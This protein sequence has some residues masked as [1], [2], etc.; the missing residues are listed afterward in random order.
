M[1]LR[2]MLLKTLETTQLFY[3]KYKFK[4]ICRLDLANEFRGSRL[5][6]VRKI[7]DNL[8]KRY[9]QGEALELGAYR[10]KNIGIDSFKDAQLLYNVLSKVKDFRLRVVFKELTIYSNEKDFLRYLKENL[11]N[12]L[13]WWEPSSDLHTLTPGIVYLKRDNGYKLRVTIKGRIPPEAAEWLLKNQDKVKL[14]PTFTLSLMEK[15]Y[16]L[17]NLYF[18]VKNERCL[19]LVELIM[20]SNIRKVDKVITSDKIV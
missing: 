15:M 8:Q 7:L 14:G 3:N 5:T 10:V 6:Y 12:V 17:E 19:S 9:D 16:Y 13:E 2:I 4:L 1:L 20:G 18:Y 11:S